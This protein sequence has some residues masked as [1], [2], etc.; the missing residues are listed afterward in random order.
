MT[1]KR[2]FSL[3]IVTAAI[4]IARF[5]ASAPT[6]DRFAGLNGARVHYVSA[7]RGPLTV[8]LIHGWSCDLTF[9]D[10]QID[11]LM[12]RA[13]VIAIDLPGHGKSDAPNVPY[14]P[15]RF[16]AGVEAV[17]RQEH[18]TNPILVGHSMGALVSRFVLDDT[19]GT[20]GLVILDSRSL[21]GGIGDDQ[22]KSF[23]ASLRGPDSDAVMRRQLEATFFVETTPRAVHDAV[24]AKM[25]VARRAVAASAYEGMIPSPAWQTQTSPVPTLAIYSRSGD[26]ETEVRL[27][28]LFTHL[29]YVRW[30]G[31][32]HFLMME[33]PQAFN[34][35]LL[36]FLSRISTTTP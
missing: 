18:V 1:H 13:R 14:T 16:A 23:A 26:A 17:L 32:G 25:L 2:V 12:K 7:G 35:A 22:R 31:V 15:Q 19:P 30:E 10:A 34:D 27:R 29:D 21:L 3:L 36:Q 24:V 6:Q 8:V 28:R 5:A 4:S 33:R 9:W 20:R 11:P